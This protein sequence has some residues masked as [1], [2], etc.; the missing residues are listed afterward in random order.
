VV[1]VNVCLHPHLPYDEAETV[2]SYIRRVIQFHTGRDG[3]SLL[4]DLGIDRR[5]FFSGADDAISQLAEAT[6]TP[7]A[8]LMRGTFQ[9]KTRFREL[10][11]EVCSVSFLRP[12]GAVVCPA[13]LQNDGSAGETW[14]IKGQ[15]AWRV[16]SLQTCILHNCRLIEPVGI[17]G[18]TISLNPTTIRNMVSIHQTPTDLELNIANRLSNTSTDA[19][20]W[21]DGQ[22]IE[23]GAKACEMV[24]AAFAHGHKFSQKGL[25]A[26]QWRHAGA[27]GYEIARNGPEAIS[28]AL[29]RIAAMSSTTAGQAGP[30]A[31]YGSLYEWIAYGSKTVEFGPIRDLLREN[32][33][34]TL[35]IEPDDVLL[36]ERVIGRRLHSVY[37]LSVQTGLHRKRL[38]KI[39]VQAGLASEDSWELAA[40]RLVFDADGAVQL[41]RD[42]IESVSLHLVPAIIGCSRTQAESLYRERIIVPVFEIDAELKI[43]KLAFASRH[44][45]ILLDSISRFPIAPSTTPDFVTLASATKRT[46]LTTG[47]IMSRVLDSSLVAYR[48]GDQATLNDIRFY[49]KDLNPI[50]TRQLSASII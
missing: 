23:Q 12:E 41:C 38:R 24:G 26:E 3:E 25:S 48:L 4:K 40:H 34:N 18:Q 9:K 32:I 33:L 16:R 37:S 19:G 14:M 39:L 6:G 11:G 46:G 13:C 50:K 5:A 47:N 29:T 2:E 49:V 7:K 20:D 22:T 8:I 31:V 36:G 43:G 1:G 45:S 17:K 44:L 35:A 28:K 15:I 10:R 30:K 42:I 21:L 27:V